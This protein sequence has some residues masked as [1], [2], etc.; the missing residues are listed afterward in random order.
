MRQLF[1]EIGAYQPKEAAALAE[2]AHLAYNK[3]QEIAAQ[4]AR[5]NYPHFRFLE[6]G[7][8]QAYLMSNDDR[9]VLVFR[10]TEPTSPKDWFTNTKLPLTDALGGQVH[11]GFWQDW[12]DVADPVVEQVNRLRYQNQPLMITGHS[13]GGALSALAALTLQQA[14]QPVQSVYTFGAPRLGNDA[15]ARNYNRQL[16]AKTFRL[17][18]H[19]DI[20]PRVPPKSWGY[21]H[22]GQLVYFDQTGRLR[23]G[24]PFWEEAVDTIK[25]WNNLGDV[26]RDHDMH[27]YRACIAQNAVQS[28]PAD[29]PTTLQL[30]N[31]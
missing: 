12:R 11:Q 19:N 4:A 16:Q 1:S 28:V 14:D 29:Y 7:N 22:V 10:G 21:S 20:V 27:A 31:S 26:V 3:P 5:W 15:F 24:S 6:R 8:T 9:L 23:Q 18:N 2:A 25:G 13:L 30:I 17:V